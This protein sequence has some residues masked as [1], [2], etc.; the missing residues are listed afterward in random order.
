MGRWW[1]WASVLLLSL[2]LQPMPLG[3]IPICDVCVGGD[4]PQEV[5]QTQSAYEHEHH[6]TFNPQ[7]CHPAN[8]T[9]IF[10]WAVSHAESKQYG[11]RPGHNPCSAKNRYCAAQTGNPAVAGES[12]YYAASYGRTQITLGKLLEWLVGDKFQSL[13]AC[14]QSL[15]QDPIIRQ[16]LQKAKEHFKYVADLVRKRSVPAAQV[17]WVK[18]EAHLQIPSF[19][20]GELGAQYQENGIT[21]A[22][23]QRMAVWERVRQMIEEAHIAPRKRGLSADQ[24]V[25]RYLDPQYSYMPNQEFGILLRH[26]HMT[27]SP[28]PR[29]AYYTG[30]NVYIYYGKQFPSKIRHDPYWNEAANDF[31]NVAIFSVPTLYD[32]LMAFYGSDDCYREATNQMFQLEHY[33]YRTGLEDPRQAATETWV[34]KAALAW[35]AGEGSLYRKKKKGKIPRWP[36]NDYAREVWGHYQRY[37]TQYY[38]KEPV[39]RA[40]AGT[41][42]DPTGEPHVK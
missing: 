15:V 36:K 11:F 9:D 13:P 35:N 18:N 3:A 10:R 40:T 26:L 25:M 39:C 1:K 24:N 23:Y 27:F 32:T 5:A 34:K 17:A 16:A 19:P 41:V 20:A 12:E 21:P 8:A 2:A 30:V 28:Y 14:L 22:L 4:S 7:N 33:G 38:G 31:G 6:C 42:S 29:S 37:Y